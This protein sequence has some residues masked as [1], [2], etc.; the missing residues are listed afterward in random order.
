MS[1]SAQLGKS[2]FKQIEKNEYLN[3]LYNQLLIAYANRMI[4]GEY[5]LDLSEHDI[6]SALRFADLLSKSNSDKKSDDHKL[7]AQEMIILLLAL[8]PGDQRVLGFA[9]SIFTNI[10]NLV[11]KQNHKINIPTGAILDRA[12]SEYLEDYL[13]IPYVDDGHYLG[14]QKKAIE[15]FDSNK[16]SFSGPTSMGKSFLIR[17]FIK[18]KIRNGENLN[19]A[20]IVPTRA[21]ITEVS[22]KILDDDFNG[23]LS[24]FGY[25][26]VTASWSPVLNNSENN[27]IFVIT[28]E[29]LLYLLINKEDLQLDYLFV[30]ESHKMLKKEGRSAYYYKTIDMLTKREKP[31]KI[32]FA[33]PNIPN[34]E[35]FLKLINKKDTG[36]E[37]GFYSELA[38]VSQFKFLVDIDNRTIEVFSSLDQEFIPLDPSAAFCG[39][40]TDHDDELINLVMKLGL[41]TQNQGKNLVYSPSVNKAT[42]LAKKLADKLDNLNDPD[43]DNLAKEIIED[44]HQ[45]YFLAQTIRKGVAYHV[46]YLPQKIRV[47]LEDLYRRGKINTLFCTNTL[48]EGVNLPADNLF[49]IEPVI[50]RK[51]MDVIDFRNLIGRI[52]RIDVKLF[53][54]VF[55]IA[56]SS[57]RSA[58]VKNYKRLMKHKPEA[59]KLPIET[60]SEKTGLSEVE[61]DSIVKS[62]LRNDLS[63]LK[64]N[65]SKSMEMIKKV[66]QILLTD[67]LNDNE[68]YLRS[69]FELTETEVLQIKSQHDA[70]QAADNDINYSPQE[71]N[72]LLHA[73][74]VEHLRY[75]HIR[76]ERFDYDE[77][78]ELLDKLSAI[79]NVGEDRNKSLDSSDFRRFLAGFI[80]KWMSGYTLKQLVTDN[81]NYRR[82]NPDKFW[83]NHKKEYYL[84]IPEHK[85]A[86]IEDTLSTLQNTVLFTLS[87][88]FHKMSAEI[89][90][91]CNLTNLSNDWY[92]FLEFGSIDPIIINL[93]KYGY[94]R[95]VAKLV[96][97]TNLYLEDDFLENDELTY[98]F[99]LSRL[100][101]SSHDES[102]RR[103]SLE[104]SYNFPELF[105]DFNKLYLG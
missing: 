3:H 91:Q 5:C 40:S 105:Q 94:S 62:L 46:G 31:P 96:K 21:L 39:A 25:R 28:P 69:E 23:T 34:P 64:A 20:I 15:G 67:I 63:E 84:D 73:I 72:Q 11:A 33:S 57:H 17:S 9:D 81:I 95:E 88:W 26:V 24:E 36:D 35:V 32:V 44:I 68:S 79:F 101:L 51:K 70:R 75:P 4:V 52:G 27:F 43:L 66:S 45:D 38:P 16:L 74:T 99:Y 10:G 104:V 19:F 58:T 55:L 100:L 12:Y 86:V 48:M 59:Q 82:D 47:K 60:Q 98:H 42:N 61:K 22:N 2:I 85:N 103:E 83:Y 65:S 54:N 13:K 102:I 97:E 78:V 56:D 6:K 93:Q 77:V 80:I 37:K 53:G 41:S 8:F 71:N 49:V 92:E 18:T 89:K 87:N 50:H 90:K 30:D 14:M 29:R 7:L 1:Q 76:N